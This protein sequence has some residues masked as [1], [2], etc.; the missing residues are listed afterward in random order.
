MRIKGILAGLLVGLC[1]TAAVAEDVSWDGFYGGI[2][3]GTG[4]GNTFLATNVASTNR[5]NFKG[6]IGG[7]TLGWNK[8]YRNVVVG[9]EFDALVSDMEGR[10]LN[11]ALSCAPGT[12]CVTHVEK[13][14]SLR[15]RVGMPLKN[16][17]LPYFTFGGARAKA[18]LA[19]SNGT[20]FPNSTDTLSGFSY[21]IG[22]EKMFKNNFSA[23][24]EAI[25]TDFGNLSVAGIARSPVEFT[26]VRLGVNYHF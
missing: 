19:L 22:V 17:C 18:Q 1:S 14:V 16:G 12:A 9:L 3:L 21:G 13:M 6:T 24:I 25:H 26:L 4:V 15:A 10:S 23:K 5:S 11:A 20:V 7:V 8:T 2:S